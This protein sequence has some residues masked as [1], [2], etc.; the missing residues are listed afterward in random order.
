MDTILSYVMN[1]VTDPKA[2][3]SPRG[4]ILNFTECVT[5]LLFPFLT[6][7]AHADWTTSIAIANTTMDDGVFGLSDACGRPSPEA[8][9]CIFFREAMMGDD[10]LMVKG[11]S[12]REDA[13]W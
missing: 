6:C 2:G 3:D 5:Y 7:G 11:R 4:A 9:C 8:S 12:R 1:I 10:G 13:Y